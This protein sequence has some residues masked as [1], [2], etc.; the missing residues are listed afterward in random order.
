MGMSGLYEP[1]DEVADP[2]SALR[3]ASA[4]RSVP[5][6]LCKDAVM[7]LTSFHAAARVVVGNSPESAYDLIADMPR[8]GEI[9]PVHRRN[10][11]GRRARGEAVLIGSTPAGD[12]TWQRRIR[13]AAAARPSNSRGKPGDPT[14]TSDADAGAA[15]SGYAVRPVADGTEVEETWALWTT[16]VST[17]WARKLT[18]LQS[19]VRIGMEQTSPTSSSSSRPQQSL[20]IPQRR[21]HADAGAARELHL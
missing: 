10:M 7:D 4:P 2:A 16:L 13:V 14:T 3:C 12:R 20:A 8:M 15:Q 19:R 1:S 11:G 17:P 6:A 18:T 9:E 5:L 21:P